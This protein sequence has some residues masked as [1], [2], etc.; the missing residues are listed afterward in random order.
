[1]WNNNSK[2]KSSIAE[3]N[4]EDESRITKSDFVDSPSI[5]APSY[6]N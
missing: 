1:M 3:V 6:S 2:L 5:S 4:I